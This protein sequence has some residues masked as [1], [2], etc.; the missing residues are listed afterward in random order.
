MQ[1]GMQ[2]QRQPAPA[3]PASLPSPTAELCPRCRKP[4][5]HWIVDAYHCL[6]FEQIETLWQEA[7]LTREKWCKALSKLME[8]DPQH[9]AV[10]R[11]ADTVD[12]MIRR[13]HEAGCELSPADRL[14][15]ELL[16]QNRNR[17]FEKASRR[18]ERLEK[19][20][21]RAHDEDGDAQIHYEATLIVRH[22]DLMEKYGRNAVRAR[23]LIGEIV[24][25]EPEQEEEE[26]KPDLPI[27]EEEEEEEGLGTLAG[28]VQPVAAGR[29]APEGPRETDTPVKKEEEEEEEDAGASANAVARVPASR[30]TAGRPERTSRRT[31]R[32]RQPYPA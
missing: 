7:K 26:R 8:D 13:L 4:D 22:F 25:L 5:D 29:R 27:K 31:S 15:M 10:A 2:P 14:D 21:E 32:R 23:R 20:L 1:R 12:Y 16:R 17:D 18:N 28:A 3:R 11:D 9:E 24:D 6:I 19:A 30:S